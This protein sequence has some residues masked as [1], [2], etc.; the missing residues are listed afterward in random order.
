MS[1]TMTL[2]PARRTGG[3]RPAAEQP[4]V[5]ELR[6]EAMRWVA[7]D[8]VTAE[9]VSLEA[10]PLPAWEPGDCIEVALPSGRWGR[11]PLCGDPWDRSRYRIAVERSFRDRL[12]RTRKSSSTN[13]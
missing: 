1:D 3:V 13:Q 7:D 5:V 2:A 9:L 12:V 10:A 11:Y 6:L 4:T 8:V